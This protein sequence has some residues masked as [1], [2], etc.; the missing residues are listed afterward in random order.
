MVKFRLVCAL[1]YSNKG[2]TLVELM[3]VIAIIS[4]LA[5]FVAPQLTRQIA[6]ANLISAHSLANQNQAAIEEYVMIYSHFPSSTEFTDWLVE[7]DGKTVSKIEITANNDQTGSF[8]IS[9][10]ALTGLDEGNYFLFSRDE[11]A[12][13]DC[14]SSLTADYLPEHCSSIAS[15]ED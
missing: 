4:V 13:W 5:S 11:D 14:T 6:K 12:N 10:N 2:F 9:L 15:S 3:V 7:G 8:K 1:P